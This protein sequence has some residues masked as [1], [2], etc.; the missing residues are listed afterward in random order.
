MTT[1]LPDEFSELQALVDDWALETRAER[2]KKRYTSSMEEIRSCYDLMMPKMASIVEHLNQFPVDDIPET[3][4]PLLY[5]SLS[6]I[7]IS[8]AVELW[9]APDNYAF[10]AER[11]HVDL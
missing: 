1:T 5:M 9:N 6:T 7:E 4:R 2:F 3:S 10:P 8:R 11:V